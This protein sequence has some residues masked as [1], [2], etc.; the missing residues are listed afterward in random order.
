MRRICRTIVCFVVVVSCPGG[1]IEPEPSVDPALPSVLLLNS[2]HNG[3]KWTDGLVKGVRSVLHDV[4]LIVEYMDT[5][6]NTRPEYLEALRDFLKK[7]YAG[8]R[9]DV[10]VS[11]DDRALEFLRAYRDEL[12]PGVPVVFCG[13][14]YASPEVRSGF[15]N[16]TGVNEDVDLVAN[17]DIIRSIYP[18]ARRLFLVD[19]T[20]ETGEKMRARLHAVL[21]IYNPRF[22]LVDLGHLSVR[23]VERRLSALDPRTDAVLMLV[24]FWDGAGR[25]LEIAEA[26]RRVS[27][28]SRVPVFVTWDFYLGQ[29][30]LGGHLTNAEDQGTAAAK[31]AQRILNGEKADD[32]PL[33]MQS[34][35]R[36]MFDARVLTRFSIP[37]NL[38]P[39]GAVLVNR[40]DSLMRY[41]I[42]SLMGL[43]A[44]ASVVVVL[45]GNILLRKRAE[46]TLLRAHNDL[47]EKEAFL[48]STIDSIADGVI[49]TDPEQKILRLNPVALA[50][51]GCTAD[52]CEG[53]PLDEL[54]ELQDIVEPGESAPSDAE[55]RIASVVV[56]RTGR[57]YR[58]AYSHSPIR[59]GDDV[60][61]GVVVFRDITRLHEVEE[62]LR[63]SRKL[64][65]I[66]RLAGGVA[67]DFNNMLAG[68]LGYAEQI[69]KHSAPDSRVRLWASRIAEIVERA[70]DLTGKLLSF[71]RK[72]KVLSAHVDI[73]AAI[74]QALDLLARGQARGVSVERHLDARET[75]VVGDPGQLLGV[76]LNL[77]INGCDAMPDGGVLRVITRNLELAAGNPF[78][79]PEGP[80]VEVRVDD[81]GVGMSADVRERI[82]EPFFSTKPFGKG[83]GLG[84]AAVH[85]T[86]AEHHGAILVESEVGEGTSFVL[87]FPVVRAEGEAPAF[88]VCEVVSGAGHVLLVDDDRNVREAGAAMLETLGYRVTCVESGSDALAVF[89]VQWHEID[90]VLLDV[91]MPGMSGEECLQKMRSLHPEV[92][93]VLC[94]GFVSDTDVAQ[95]LKDGGLQGFLAKP[96][97]IGELSQAL[98]RAVKG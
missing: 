2:Y 55:A 37:Q 26:A 18:K 75:T 88:P 20:T 32:I 50:L 29:G 71:S 19:D 67:H 48:K 38:L 21:D 87:V 42:Y 90:V 35:A 47:L 44:L 98:V 7:K 14:N 46:A 66:G 33:V 83:T 10:I 89:A 16:T 73:H 60:V 4:D 95:L 49:I 52:Q 15:P 72:G 93:V 65:A 68:L 6:R 57:R 45:I 64:E 62:Q 69:E 22:D 80:Y 92:K 61:G 94:S 25:F 54:V 11:A 24:Y 9:I 31:L 78:G 56:V 1:A 53:R 41:L 86:V 82:F 63:H 13:V 79:L 3:Y 40:P 59:S 23:E 34:P 58:I 27:R 30:V 8:V 12:F 70:S 43:G 36:P 81:T 97:R 76:F 17:L 85:G 96:Y 5:K 77:G 74:S 84:L 51:L 39:K 28:A 91:V